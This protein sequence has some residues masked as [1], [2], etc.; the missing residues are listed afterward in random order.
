MVEGEAMVVPKPGLHDRP[1]AKFVKD[2][3]EANAGHF[4][5]PMTLGT[6]YGDGV[7]IRAEGEE[8]ALV[9]IPSREEEE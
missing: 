5:R 2:G 8:A 1:A 4:L 3:R 6:G 7:V 9:A